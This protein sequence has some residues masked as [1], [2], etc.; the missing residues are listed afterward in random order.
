M[1]MNTQHRFQVNHHQ[2]FLIKK[3]VS[4]PQMIQ[5]KMVHMM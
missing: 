3:V 4:I 2:E 1:D 5:M